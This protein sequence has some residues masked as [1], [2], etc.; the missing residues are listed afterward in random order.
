MNYLEDDPKVKNP[1][2]DF[3][4]MMKK[5]EKRRTSR[6]KGKRT[7]D[8]TKIHASRTKVRNAKK[9]SYDPYYD[10]ENYYLEDDC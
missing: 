5:K 2:V 6:S 1:D 8:K 7:Y 4:E 10:Y 3:D 9:I